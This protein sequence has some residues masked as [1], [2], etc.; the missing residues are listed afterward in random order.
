MP[1]SVACNV[2]RTFFTVLA[3]CLTGQVAQMLRNP[4]APAVEQ[5]DEEVVLA[6]PR[7]PRPED[8]LPHPEKRRRR[9][10]KTK[11]P[12]AS[13]VVPPM[14]AESDCRE[15]GERRGVSPPVQDR[16]ADPMTPR[17]PEWDGLAI[18]PTNTAGLTPPCAPAPGFSN[19][20]DG[21]ASQANTSSPSPSVPVSVPAPLAAPL[22]AEDASKNNATD[23]PAAS[24][25][26][27]AGPMEEALAEPGDGPQA[28]PV[29]EARL[30]WLL[31]RLGLRSDSPPSPNGSNGGA[32]WT[33]GD[34][35]GRR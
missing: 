4:P 35:E 9:K 29:P 32:A 14:P 21:E 7:V 15:A 22:P 1:A 2:M 6:Q 23:V 16:T 31:R 18:R 12:D 26:C 24:G 3:P 8:V 34:H 13:V 5:P 17:S 28:T 27:A 33:N 11:A 20:E 30:H 25:A 19:S 10:D